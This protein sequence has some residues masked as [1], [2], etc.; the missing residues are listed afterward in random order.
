M[1]TEELRTALDK[2]FKSIEGHL[3]SIPIKDFNRLKKQGLYLNY[4]GSGLFLGLTTHLTYHI[5][6]KINNIKTKGDIRREVSLEREELELELIK[7]I[8]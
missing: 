8:V 7:E 1:T 5:Q 4:D 3:K 2:T 6:I